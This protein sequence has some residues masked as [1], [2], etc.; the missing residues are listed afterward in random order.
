MSLEGRVERLEEVAGIASM[1]VI[2]K[3]GVH[4]T[5]IEQVDAVNRAM[6]DGCIEYLEY[7]RRNKYLFKIP[8]GNCY[9]VSN[10]MSGVKPSEDNHSSFKGLI[11]KGDVKVVAYLYE[12][13]KI[14]QMHPSNY[15]HAI[16][17][18]SVEMYKY[19]SSNL[20]KVDIEESK[21]CSFLGTK[22]YL[23]LMKYMHSKTMIQGYHFVLEASRY[24]NLECLKYFH[25]NI[26]NIKT[27]T[28]NNQR[29]NYEQMKE[30]AGPA[31]LEFLQN[32]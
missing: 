27:L 2:K 9:W 16:Q 12:T 1:D 25:E 18:G 5:G 14:C 7:A 24:N 28:Y 32:L 31:C 11:R 4:K 29:L 10:F 22:G 17:S 15:Y 23:D 30:Y 6:N 3:Y 26:Q 21:L 13:L 20:E 8:G 19:I